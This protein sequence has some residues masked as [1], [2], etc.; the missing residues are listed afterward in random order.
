[1]PTCRWTCTACG[2]ANAAGAH[3]CAACECPASATAREIAA[4]RERFLR[5]GG[6]LRGDAAAAAQAD[7]SA[8]DVLGR[9]LLALVLAGWPGARLQ[10]TSRFRD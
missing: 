1:M 3:A 4:C 9:P 8:F 10:P 5:Q 6:A 7:L 2:H